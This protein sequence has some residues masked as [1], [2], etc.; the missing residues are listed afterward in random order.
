M[1]TNPR[2]KNSSDNPAVQASAAKTKLSVASLGKI[3]S[4]TRKQGAATYPS[5]RLPILRKPITWFTSRSPVKTT[6]A[7]ATR[8]ESPPARPN[9][10]RSTARETHRQST[11]ATINHWKK[12]VDP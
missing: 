11:T 8:E 7:Q 3:F 12:M 10:A 6:V 9:S 1:N 2:Y 4:V 5:G